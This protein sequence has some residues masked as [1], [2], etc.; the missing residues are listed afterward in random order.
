MHGM[1]LDD[2]VQCVA[3]G[4]VNATYKD[5]QS[6]ALVYSLLSGSAESSDEFDVD[7]SSG[8]VVTRR[9]LDRESPAPL[10]LHSPAAAVYLLVSCVSVRETPIIRDCV[11]V[12]V[13]VLDVN[14]NRPVVQQVDHYFI[15]SPASSLI[16]HTQGR[17][18]GCEPQTS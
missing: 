2:V 4:R 17:A 6:R 18:S 1:D 7:S 15:R 12:S 10:S 3:E 11:N 14:D 13:H 9:S 5:Q 16:I 8:Q